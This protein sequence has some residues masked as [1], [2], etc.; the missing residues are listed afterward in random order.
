MLINRQLKP[1]M[2]FKKRKMNNK[3]IQIVN[4]YIF[5]NISS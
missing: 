1:K 3:A 2:S 5:F 4:I